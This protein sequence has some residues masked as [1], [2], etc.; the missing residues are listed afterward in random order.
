MQ[1]HG[2][3]SKR[4]LS[5]ADATYY[6]KNWSLEMNETPALLIYATYRVEADDVI[7][8]QSLATRVAAMAKARDG[9]AFLDVA[10]DVS[11]SATFRFTEGW[12]DQVA[13]DTHLASDEFQAALK[14]AGALGIIDYSADVYS[15][16]GKTALNMP[17]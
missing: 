4:Q 10:Q 1:R 11:D 8:F 2:R 5:V 3:P 13:L 7:A 12:R 14:E 17:S 6:L 9:C 15:V 16:A